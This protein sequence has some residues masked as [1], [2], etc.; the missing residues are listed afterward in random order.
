[1]VDP[2]TRT[3]RPFKWKRNRKPLSQEIRNTYR[4]LV[5]A[6]LFLGLMT[7]GTYLYMNS[8]APA[9]GYELKQLQNDYESLQSDLRKLDRKVVDA[10]S[11]INL[12][13]NAALKKMRIAES[14]DL[15]Y[16]QGGNVAENL[17]PLPR[18]ND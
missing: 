6:I 4:T 15:S 3:V 18:A 12:E 17:T 9:K 11:F 16:V 10:Q 14:H 8:L 1:M 13:K 5:C 2:L 7:S